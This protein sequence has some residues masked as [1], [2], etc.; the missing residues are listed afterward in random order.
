MPKTRRSL[1]QRSEVNW[2]LH[3][4]VISPGTPNLEIHS[5]RNTLAHGAIES[6]MGIAS[7]QQV[8]LSIMVK[9]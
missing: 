3:S 2:G 7:V 8:N 9:T 5:W 6:V 1:S 4:E